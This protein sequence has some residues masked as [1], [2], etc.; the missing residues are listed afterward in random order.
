MVSTPSTPTLL[1]ALR[2]EL[3]KVCGEGGAHSSGLRT[4]TKLGL[5]VASN[6]KA[7]GDLLGAAVQNGHRLGESYREDSPNFLEKL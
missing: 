2:G 1:N 7:T 6:R 3:G 4:E 5:A